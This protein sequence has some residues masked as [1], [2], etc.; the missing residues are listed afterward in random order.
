[1]NYIVLFLYIVV[2]HFIGENIGYESNIAFLGSLVRTFGAKKEYKDLKARADSLNP[3]RPLYTIPEEVNTLRESAESMTQGDSP[4]Y[5]RMKSEAEGA[6]TRFVGQARNFADSG[7]SML[8]AASQGDLNTR[9]NVGDINVQNQS[10]RANQMSNFQRA[11]MQQAGY[12]D[13]AFNVNQMQPYLQEESDKRMFEQAALQQ[14][15][16]TTEALASLGDGM[17]ETSGMFAKLFTGGV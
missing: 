9:R 7:S 16:G 13:Q 1:M 2:F 11:L 4:G 15:Q 14:R 5:G 10:F 8:Q 3:V 12:K 6:G 17:M